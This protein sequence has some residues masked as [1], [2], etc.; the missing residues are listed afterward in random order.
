MRVVV[1]GAT[2]L[3]GS[4]LVAAL[5]AR[6]DE[7]IA[8]TRDPA[9][10]RAALGSDAATARAPALERWDPL[11]GP[12]PDRVLSGCD[13]VV[14]LAGENVAQRWTGRARE[15]IRESR[16]RGTHN[17]VAGIEAADPRPAALISSS[18]VGYYGSRGEEPI[19]EEARPGTDFL[20]QVCVDWEAEARGAEPLGLRSVQV[21][22]G[23][24][25]DRHGGA[26][27]KMLPA[28]R[29]G[30]GGPVAGGRQYTPWIHRADVVGMMLA[31]LDGQDWSGPVNATAPEPVTNREFSRTLGRVLH[32]P[33]IA[34]VPGFA[35]RLLY[36]DMAEVVTGGARAVPAKALVL[37]YHFAHRELE[38]ALRAALA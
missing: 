4:A 21:R 23:V 12:A 26:L 13:A 35:L 6:G 15:A 24:V 36:G 28:F 18:A 5:A 14:N 34:P 7:V 29:A 32:R 25:L 3:I 10:A 9:R 30:V 38:A 19:D 37:G 31:A 11:A 16:V 33:A 17:L 1:T 22:T 27:A 8:L 2:G 20:A